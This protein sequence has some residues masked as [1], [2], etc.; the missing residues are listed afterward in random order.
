MNKRI[1][2]FTG[3]GGV[4]KTTCAAATA[5]R[6]AEMGYRTLVMSADPAHS[7]SDALDTELGP[8]PREVEPKL[9]AQEV[10]EQPVIR[11]VLIHPQLLLDDSAL[12]LHVLC[13]DMRVRDQV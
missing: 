2:L 4:G 12:L 13:G 1:L 9:H 3:K 6:A 11:R 10:E 5:L 8:E 7:L